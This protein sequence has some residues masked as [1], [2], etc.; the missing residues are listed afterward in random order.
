MNITKINL[1]VF[2][3]FCD[4]D[5]GLRDIAFRSWLPEISRVIRNLHLYL[6]EKTVDA[7]L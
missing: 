6:K 4:P 5:T 2:L 1:S 7:E 3:G